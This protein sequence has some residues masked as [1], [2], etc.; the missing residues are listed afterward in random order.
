M[1]FFLSCQPQAAPQNVSPTQIR[2]STYHPRETFN[3]SDKGIPSFSVWKPQMKL[4]LKDSRDIQLF[5]FWK[6][7]C[8]KCKQGSVSRVWVWIRVQFLEDA[9]YHLFSPQWLGGLHKGGLIQKYN[10]A[11]HTTQKLI[12]EFIHGQFQ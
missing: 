11:V 8:S 4:E 2:N 7:F 3:L 12:T 9:V 1:H 5:N 6:F 10:S